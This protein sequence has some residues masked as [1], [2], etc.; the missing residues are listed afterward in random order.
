MKSIYQSIFSLSLIFCGTLT[1]TGCMDETEP[2][3][4]ATSKQI[5]ES[6]MAAHAS[7]M[8][9]PAYFNET[10]RFKDWIDDD[11]IHYCFGYGAMMHIRDIMTADLSESS[12][13]Y[14]HWWRWATNQYQGSDYRYAQYLWNY[15]YGFILAAN[16]MIGSIDESTATAEQLGYLG[17]GY[18]FRALI[19]LDMG[20]M[21]E[22]LPN[23]KTSSKNS[24]DNDVLGLTVPIVTDKTTEDSARNNPR[25]KHEEL[26][27][28]IQD[29]LDKAEQLIVNLSERANHTLPNLACV[30]G[31][32]AR[33]YMWNEDYPNA[34]KYARMA[35][36]NSDVAPISKD[37]ALNTSS[38][39]N[40]AADFL[41]A[42]KQNSEAY[43]VQ[44]G[45]IN[46]TSW[47]SNQTT[48]GYTGAATGSYNLIDV[49]L[50]NSI[51]NTDWRKLEFRAPKD[52]YLAGRE[53]F[54]TPEDARDPE[55]KGMAYYAALKFRPNQG[56]RTDYATGAASAYPIMR[57]EE[58]YFIEAEAA[59]HQDPAKGLELLKA[60]M[61]TYR[62]PNY[63]TRA[64]ST[65]EVVKEAVLQKRI[66]LWG[67]GQTFFDIKRLNM[68][69]TRGYPGTNFYEAVRL[70]TN[71][72]PAWMN[73]VIVQS[74]PNN[75]KAI[76]GWNNPDPSN[77]YTP[78][79]GE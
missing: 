51:S 49:N 66:E 68:S 71:G 38:G 6:S 47:L 55:D 34:Q 58:M 72:R 2:T 63:T 13:S 31:L 42:S 10:E 37:K 73:I 30:Y 41:W 74:E 8:A 4:V 20:R 36:D 40:D 45:I 11:G 14:S 17:A 39:F 54:M 43:A 1:L 15:H 53:P 61:L 65:E 29:D 25:A 12:N 56:N 75:N 18:A 24:D 35:I 46:W 23:D 44:T 70:N 3:T 48:F 7:L 32:K 21:Y 19:Y 22:F 67:E 27:K 28:F 76:M 60:F 64:A 33:L 16:S 9:L 5:A 78:W 57:V 77:L 26:A 52:G 69:V 62:D 59:A 50:Y 79:T